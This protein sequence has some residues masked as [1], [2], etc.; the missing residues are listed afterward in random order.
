MFYSVPFTYLRKSVDVAAT[1]RTIEVFFSGER[2]A[3]HSRL[4]G[5]KGQ[6]ATNPSHMPDSHRDYTEWNGDRFRNW[7]RE[8]G[9]ACEQVVDAILRSRTVEQQAY[10][11]CRALLDLGRKH[12]DDILESAC[13]KALEYSKVPTYKTV[14]TIAAKLVGE[15][16]KTPNEHAYLRGSNYFD[17]STQKETNNND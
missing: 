17:L 14:K 13:S 2:I 11:S 8:K 3:I 5:A 10:R 4:Y 9:A 16:T 7:A 12:G 1:S 6:Y 15:T